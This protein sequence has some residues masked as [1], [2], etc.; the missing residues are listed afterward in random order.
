MRA[1]ERFNPELGF[2]FSTYASWWVK[3]AII[4]SIHR[5]DAL[6]GIPSHIVTAKFQVEDLERH[7]GR[8]PTLKEQR[9]YL[10]ISEDTVSNL[11]NLPV[12]VTI[13][14]SPIAGDESK[15]LLI[16]VLTKPVENADETDM[17]ARIYR[18]QIH[19]QIEEALKELSPRDREIIM[20]WANGDFQSFDI[21][22]QKSK[23][24]R[25]RVRQIILKATQM[26]RQRIKK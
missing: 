20:A 26:L 21:I 25:E 23:L 15:T 19:K 8:A 3:Q 22:G 17:E 2:K 5:D 16:E 10:R 1:V 6:I 18:E 11:K 9:E 4:R 24:T 12:A 7:L 13:L 14:D